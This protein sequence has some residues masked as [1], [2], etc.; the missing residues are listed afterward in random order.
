MRRRYINKLSFR[1]W[2]KRPGEDGSKA[3]R[4]GVGLGYFAAAG[5]AGTV[6]LNEI[7]FDIE[8]AIRSGNIGK[9]RA[10]FVEYL[11]VS[12]RTVFGASDDE[13]KCAS[14]MRGFNFEKICL[15]P[16]LHEYLIVEYTKRKNNPSY[17]ITNDPVAKQKTIDYIKFMLELRNFRGDGAVSQ[18]FDTHKFKAANHYAALVLTD[19]LALV[20]NFELDEVSLAHRII[21][22]QDPSKKAML[23]DNLKQVDEDLYNVLKTVESFGNE[24]SLIDYGELPQDAKVYLNDLIGNASK[25]DDELA[26]IEAIELGKLLE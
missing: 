19:T 18:L 22:T 17:D 6:A 26:L 9:V 15:L 14:Q 1:Q 21:I 4:I 7:T 25:N 3:K 11:D 12:R 13:L 10:H 16:L 20:D 2:G 23:Y 24:Q 5:T 8:D